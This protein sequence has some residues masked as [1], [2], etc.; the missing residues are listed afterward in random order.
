FVRSA[1]DARM[2]CKSEVLVPAKIENGLGATVRAYL[3]FHLLRSVTQ[4]PLL[5]ELLF[6][7]GCGA[8]RQGADEL[9][10][11]GIVLLAET[12][13]SISGPHAGRI[14]SKVSL[15]SCFTADTA[16]TCAVSRTLTRTKTARP[17][18][19]WTVG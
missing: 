19:G 5:V 16:T 10:R 11:H 13:Q 14:S 7:E 2:L 18:R 15:S 12:P 3:D 1:G 9:L 4:A 17:A 8:H 6:S